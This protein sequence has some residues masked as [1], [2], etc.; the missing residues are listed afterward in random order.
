[1]EQGI[2]ANK[3]TLLSIIGKSKIKP[4]LKATIRDP[5][6]KVNFFLCI[7]ALFQNWKIVT[8]NR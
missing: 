3:S 1:M 2:H 8:L 5:I 6:Q 7:P 4:V